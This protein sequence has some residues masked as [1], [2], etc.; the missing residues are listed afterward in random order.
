MSPEFRDNVFRSRCQ[1]GFDN[2]IVFRIGRNGL[3]SYG[4][5]DDFKSIFEES[6]DFQDL[7]RMQAKFGSAHNIFDFTE[8][9]RGNEVDNDTT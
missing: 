5:R 7:L 6:Y 8:Y 4:R 1:G 3:N 2:L 9:T